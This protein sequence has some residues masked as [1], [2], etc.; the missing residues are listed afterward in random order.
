MGK[1]DERIID[2]IKQDR[3]NEA[4]SILYSRTLKKVIHFVK[5]NSGT[6]NEA[7]DVFQDAVVVFF[8]AVKENKLKTDT[9]VD[10]YI[11]TVARNVWFRKLNRDK[12]II[13][14][15]FD[16]ESMNQPEVSFFDGLIE[17]EKATAFA[18]V[19]NTLQERCKTLLT[20]IY[21]H[22]HTMNEIC[23]KMGT[24]Y[25][26]LLELFLILVISKFNYFVNLQFFHK[27]IPVF[28]F[29]FQK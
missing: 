7:E 15:D 19:F 4:L 22:K 1:E 20:Y 13:T 12:K 26:K 27:K 24:I 11:F 23:E 9:S 10:G 28:P 14:T 21:F 18:S 25:E 3:D 17:E 2:A 29:F 6:Q 8:D 5:K 16:Y